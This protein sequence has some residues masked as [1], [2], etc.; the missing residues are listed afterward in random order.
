M[1]NRYHIIFAIEG[2]VI[3]AVFYLIIRQTVRHFFDTST[4]IPQFP[5]VGIIANVIGLGI[6]LPLVVLITVLVVRRL[7][8]DKV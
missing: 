7:G 8:L 3:G 6:V 2:V 1:K 5:Y 4:L